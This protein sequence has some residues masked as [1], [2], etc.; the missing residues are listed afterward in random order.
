[1]PMRLVGI[2]RSSRDSATIA[3]PRWS[4]RCKGCGWLNVF[5]PLRPGE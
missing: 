3:A 1:M 4:W 5:I 2:F